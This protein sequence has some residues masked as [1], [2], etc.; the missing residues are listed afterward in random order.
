MSTT[1][2]FVLVGLL[3]GGGPAALIL[4][5]V[6]WDRGTCLGVAMAEL[7][8]A[9][10]SFA[11]AICALAMTWYPPTGVPSALLNGARWIVYPAAT[12]LVATGVCDLVWAYRFAA[13]ARRRR[14]W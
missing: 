11:G 9:A 3:L 12:L 14:E 1:M 8:I 7:A 5:K 6:G 4:Y 13:I 10:Y 2:F